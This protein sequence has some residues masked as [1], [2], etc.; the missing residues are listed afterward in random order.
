MMRSE[1]WRNLSGG[2]AGS[3]PGANE[4]LIIFSKAEVPGQMSHLPYHRYYPGI[5]PLLTFVLDDHAHTIVISKAAIMSQKS[6]PGSDSNN[7]DDEYDMQLQSKTEYYDKPIIKQEYKEEEATRQYDD[8]SCSNNDLPKGW[9]KIDHDSGMPIYMNTETRVCSFSK[10]YFLG[11]N[12]LKNHEIPVA[13]IP[14]LNQKLKN[15]TQNEKNLPSTSSASTSNRCPLTLS[16]TEYRNYCRKIFKFRNIKVYKFKSWVKRREHQRKQKVNSKGKHFQ[17][18]ASVSSDLNSVVK[19]ESNVLD[20]EDPQNMINFEGKNYIGILH[21]YIQRIMKSSSHSYEVK[22]LEQTKY[23]YLCTV[24]LD[25][26][27]YGI[28]TGSTKKQAKIDAARA[29]LQIL[30]PS[31]KHFQTDNSSQTKN[32]IQENNY[33]EQYKIFDKLSVKDTIIPQI[34]AESTESTPYEMLKLCIKRNFGEGTNL[35]CEM[36]QME[37]GSDTD[38]YYRCTMAVTKYSATVICK[39]KLDGRQKGAQ[40][41]LKVLHPHVHYFGSLLRLYSHQHFE[42]NEKKLNEPKPKTKQYTAQPDV[43]LLKKLKK[44]ML[45]LESQTNDRKKMVIRSFYYYYLT[46]KYANHFF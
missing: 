45:K 28:G 1:H 24:V 30:L 2:L 27:Q 31:V 32:E 17:R 10:P 5:S 34:C 14:C 3:A 46:Y 36:E 35:L 42:Y 15:E 7:S 23:P 38:N 44:T 4:A 6:T 41:L 22:E 33:L 26:I 12:S 13:N 43:N 18:S 9:E 8:N 20:P 39:D 16:H 19:R 25:G 40:A 37:S 11:I 29:T 21:E